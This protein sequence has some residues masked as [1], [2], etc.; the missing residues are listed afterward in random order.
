MVD[1]KSLLPTIYYQAD[2]TVSGN[3][4]LATDIKFTISVTGQQDFQ[5]EA[6]IQDTTDFKNNTIISTEVAGEDSIYDNIDNI[7]VTHSVGGLELLNNNTPINMHYGTK[8]SSIANT[9]V[10]YMISNLLD[11]GSDLHVELKLYISASDNDSNT[12]V[13]VTI[14]ND[15]RFTFVSDVF[16]TA[17]AYL[18]SIVLDVDIIKGVVHY[19]TSDIVSSALNVES[20]ESDIFSTKQDELTFSIEAEAI[21]GVVHGIDTSL[22]STSNPVTTSGISLDIR[23]WSMFTTGFFLENEEFKLATSSAWVDVIDYLWEIDVDNTYI[24]VNDV[25]VSGTTFSGIDNGYRVYYNPPGDFSHEDV[26]TYTLHAQNIVGDVL[27]N[28]YN[29]LYGYNVSFNEF[30]DWGPNKKVDILTN[31]DNNAYCLNTAAESFYFITKDLQAINLVS[32]IIPIVPLDLGSTIRT[33]GKVFYYGETYHITVSGIKDYAGN[34]LSPITYS[35]TI[36]NPID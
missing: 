28:S 29:L 30:L 32:K 21:P 13:D 12:I 23:T 4:I 22:F 5:V 6:T 8:F 9:E 26:F 19:I 11:K 16:C 15:K 34:E 31:I 18:K 20:V 2:S 10:E 24:M 33:Q 35:F 17:E 3:V 1:W 36:E 27:E 7:V 25:V 14:S